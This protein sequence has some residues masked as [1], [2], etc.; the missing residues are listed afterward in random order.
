MASEFFSAAICIVMAVWF[1]MI[2]SLSDEEHLHEHGGA[3]DEQTNE[4][5]LENAEKMSVACAVTLVV[6]SLIFI[7]LGV[8][9]YLMLLHREGLETNRFLRLFLGHRD[10]M[11]EEITACMNSSNCPWLVKRKDQPLRCQRTLVLAEPSEESESLSDMSLDETTGKLK[12]RK[13]K[14]RDADDE[15]GSTQSDLI[16]SGIETS[17][18]PDILYRSRQSHSRL[19]FRDRSRPRLRKIHKKLKKLLEDHGE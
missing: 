3:I 18:D 2:A 1:T 7:K 4:Q 9:D 15:D 16:I 10:R 6:A 12:R 14:T 17:S 8:D 5:T 19:K 11:A 13:K